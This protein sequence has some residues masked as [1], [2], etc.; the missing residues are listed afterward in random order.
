MAASK[1]VYGESA[2]EWSPTDALGYSKMLAL[3]GVFYKRAGA[4]ADS[5]MNM[6]TVVVDKIASVTQ[7]CALSHEIAHSPGYSLR[8]RHGDGGRDDEQQGELQHGGIDQ[9]PHGQGGSRRRRG[10]RVG[11]S[12]GVVRLFRPYSGNAQTRRRHSDA[13]HR[14][15][16]GNLRFGHSG[17]RANRSTARCW[18]RC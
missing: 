10:R 11:P 7:A 12:Q 6:R 4:K 13:E 18:A 16:A 15:R 8:G 3:T 9:R 17:A 5:I 1:G 2:G 14:R